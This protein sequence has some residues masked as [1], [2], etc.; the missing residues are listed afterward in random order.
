MEILVRIP[1]EDEKIFKLLEEY[2]FFP[3]MLKDRIEFYLNSEELKTINCYLRGTEYDVFIHAYEFGG[4]KT[5]TGSGIVVC[6]PKGEMLEPIEIFRDGHLANRIHA[7]FESKHCFSV[8]ATKRGIISITEGKIEQH[9]AG[10]FFFKTID[11]WKGPLQ[12][13][14]RKL[15]DFE[16]A[17]TVAKQKANCFHCRHVHFALRMLS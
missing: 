12:E 4:G 14:P 9:P 2:K 8:H 13:M 3:T 1:G 5:N 10:E 17:A 16:K 11:T 6:G 7:K 15:C